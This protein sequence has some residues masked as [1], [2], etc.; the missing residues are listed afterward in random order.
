MAIHIRA[1]RDGR[2]VA[3]PL[4]GLA[5]AALILVGGITGWDHLW[6]QIAAAHVGHTVDAILDT[7]G[8]TFLDWRLWVTVAVIG[9]LERFYP[10]RPGG[11]LFTVGAAQ[12][13]MYFVLFYVF[14]LTVV[15]AYFMLLGAAEELL[16]HANLESVL[17]AT[18]AVI[19]AFVVGDLLFWVSHVVRHRVPAFWRVHE[20]H[21]SQRSLNAFAGMRLHFAEAM[22]ASTI[23]LVPA[24]L[25]GISGEGATSL[26]TFVIF[27]NYVVHSNI[28]TNFGPLRYILVT[29]Q[30]HR[31]HHSI[32]DEHRDT[33]FGGVLVVW[34]RLF[35]TQVR[36]FDAYPDTGVT[37]ERFPY[38]ESARPTMLAK[39]YAR[40]LVYPFRRPG[41]G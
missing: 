6:D 8:R 41:S 21:H 10:A 30:S 24:A 2:P 11:G 23:V 38:E 5:V 33:N 1:R 4:I 15:S 16:P 18:G 7:W 20:V 22:I 17:G 37:N 40:Q 39:T 25:L 32:E 35:G 27:A 13:A 19:V 29:P 12:D 31:V 26:A 3:G 34:D 14:Q 9:L 36:D 28:R